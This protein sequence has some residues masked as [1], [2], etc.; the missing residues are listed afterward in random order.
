[1]RYILIIF[2]FALFPLYL[3]A[4]SPNDQTEIDLA[5]SLDKQAHLYYKQDRHT[6][7]ETLYKRSLAIKEKILGQEH[8]DVAT[9]PSPPLYLLVGVDLPVVSL[10]V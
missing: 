5:N 2:I 6:D 9:T 1:M 7:A 3:F 10:Y 4:V 8:P